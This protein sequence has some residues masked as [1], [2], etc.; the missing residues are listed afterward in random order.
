MRMNR[1]SFFIAS[2]LLA[3][4]ARNADAQFGG[5]FVCANCATEPTQASIQVMHN[6]EYAKQLLQYAIQVQQLADAIRNTA[7]GGPA[8]LTSIAGDLNQLANVVQ[9]GSALAYSLAGQDVVFRQTFPGYQPVFGPAPAGGTYQ[10]QYSK[11]AQTSLATTQGILRGVGLQ[12]KMLATEQGVLSILRTL[13]ASNLL[14]RNDAINLTGQLAAEQVGQL[15]KLRE[16]QLE[17]MTSKAAYQGYV[18]QRQAASESATQQFFTGA[19][20]TGDGATF[21]PGLH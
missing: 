18:I 7:H 3:F 1:P 12:G 15:Q 21:R 20:V 14:D 16:L 4:L 2:A 6:L 10:S 13:T 9:G 17:D 5:V 19:A 11:W 8:S